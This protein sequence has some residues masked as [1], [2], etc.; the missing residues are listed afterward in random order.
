MG[1]RLLRPSCCRKEIF[2]QMS[3]ASAN[4]VKEAIGGRGEGEKAGQPRTI[5]RKGH[6]N[7]EYGDGMA[8]VRECDT[9]TTLKNPE[10]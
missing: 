4:V 10:Q 5:Y 9:A 8:E 6:R 7:V 1:M 3:K 2:L